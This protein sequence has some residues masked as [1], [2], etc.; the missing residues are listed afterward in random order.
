MVTAQEAKQILLE[1]RRRARERQAAYME[2]MRAKGYK[3]IAILISG[4]AYQL[5]DDAAKNSN[6]AKSDLLSDIIIK[7]FTDKNLESVN[8]V[9]TDINIKSGKSK[10]IS[11]IDTDALI[12]QYRKKGLSYQAIADRLTADFIPTATGKP[13]W[14]KGT[15]S[16][17]VK[18]LKKGDK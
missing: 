2:E 6:S 18:R 5:L 3:R 10:N 15:I 17:I 9:S 13:E 16:N 8:N 4:E 11:D 1:R 12:M 7:A 14:S